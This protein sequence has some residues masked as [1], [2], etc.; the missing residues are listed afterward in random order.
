MRGGKGFAT[1]CWFLHIGDFDAQRKSHCKEARGRP[2]QI[3]RAH[4]GDGVVWPRAT[5]GLLQCPA[6][7][8]VVDAYCQHG[9]QK[10]GPGV[11]AATQKDYC[12]TQNRQ[13]PP[14][15]PTRERRHGNIQHRAGELGIDE[16]KR[17]LI[18][19]SRIGLSPVAFTG[20]PATRP[21]RHPVSGGG[22]HHQGVR[23]FPEDDG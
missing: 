3:D 5:N 22:H 20:K 8:S 16:M 13:G 6:D 1:D 23:R 18:H 10:H 14:Y 2:C 12:S 11:E 7:E 4:P 17:G 9:G 21:P 19:C 15:S